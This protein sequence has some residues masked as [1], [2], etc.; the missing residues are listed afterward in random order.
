MDTAEIRLECLKLA[1][2]VTAATDPRRME[3]LARR[4][5]EFVTTGTLTAP[6]DASRSP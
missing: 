5:A 2:E 4:W 6:D 3:E 1:R